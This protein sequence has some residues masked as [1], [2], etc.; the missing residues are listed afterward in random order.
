MGDKPQAQLSPEEADR[1]MRNDPQVAAVL[2]AIRRG[3][4]PAKASGNSAKDPSGE[5][6]QLLDIIKQLNK[7]G[8]SAAASPA[9]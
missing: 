3:G 5:E 2:A 7:K 8:G 6:K 4:L 9:G 1:A